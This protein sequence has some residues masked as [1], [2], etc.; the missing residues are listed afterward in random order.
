MKIDLFSPDGT[1]AIATGASLKVGS[2]PT[3]W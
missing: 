2:N 1:V 3:I